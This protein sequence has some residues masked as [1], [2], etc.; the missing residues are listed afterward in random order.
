[1][2]MKTK[3]GRN[4]RC[5]CGSGKQ[6]KACCATQRAPTWYTVQDRVALFEALDGL[7]AAHF[8][9]EAAM[10]YVDFWGPFV[11]R[12][13]ELS[14][15]VLHLS[16]DVEFMAFVCDHE[17]EPH[18]TAIDLLLEQRS[19]LSP[20]ARA[21]GRAIRAA[22]LRAYEAIAIS[23]GVSITLR[24]VVNGR[25]V[26]VAERT[27][28]RSLNRFDWIA[29]RVVERGPSGKPEMERGVLAIPRSAH[30]WLREHLTDL[31]ADPDEG[32]DLGWVDAL[33]P[34]IAHQ[35]WVECFLEPAIPQL[36]NT[37]GELT[38][39]TRVHFDVK[40]RARVEAALDSCGALDRD[41]SRWNWFGENATGCALQL[42]SFEFKGRGLVLEANSKQRGERGAQ[43]LSQL[44]GDAVIHRATTHE[45]LEPQ[46]RAELK[47][48]ARGESPSAAA[49]QAKGPPIPP[50]IEEAL[51]LDYCGKHYRA[52][53]D[54]A[55]PALDHQTPR[56]A[57]TRP[58]MR[59]RVIELLERFEA[60]YQQCLRDGMPAYDASWIRAELGLQAAAAQLPPPLPHERLGS[61]ISG[62]S[63]RVADVAEAVR[64]RPGFDEASTVLDRESIQQILDVQ[65]FL[66][67]NPRSALSGAPAWQRRELV[68]Y[69]DLALNFMLHRRK[70]FWVDGALT[71]LLAQTNL[72]LP[73]RDL[74]TP[75]ASFALVFTDRHVLSQAERLLS[76][77][78]A[79]LAGLILHVATVLV[80]ERHGAAG[81]A[82][83]LTFAFDALGDDLP[84]LV[85]HSLPLVD[86]VP[87]Q[88][89]FPHEDE[90]S[91]L[92]PH[93]EPF[94]PL[95]ELL[96]ITV[97][98]I[99]YA[100]SSG[101]EVETRSAE[102]M[103]SSRGNAGRALTAESVFYLPGA[104]DVVLV[105]SLQ[106]LAR[107]DEGRR[108]MRR[109]LARGRW[110]K[111]AKNWKDQRLRWT[112]PHWKGPDLTAVIER[113][114][115]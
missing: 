53:I 62:A 102:S 49:P 95:P 36:Q 12:N 84:A 38:L 114:Y 70:A 27:A 5:P 35:L 113:A 68:P 90:H 52:W 25:T 81:R 71:Y 15:E 103:G 1:M 89:L 59:A 101:V 91:R 55:L 107:V 92:E 87:V 48:R 96:R 74:R 100:T 58:A 31:Y 11:G 63:R 7:I 23:P 26:T 64:M 73:A 61:F 39:I 66:T 4:D 24:D 65:R 2:H 105:R 72:E 99:V 13:E 47:A 37:D 83:D 111:A 82:L 88:S 28:S 98:A 93:I 9:V 17:L 8:Q 20:G 6:A 104:P 110:R 32:E 14:D 50:A 51:V 106:E 43:L 56:V 86:D 34:R 115:R 80:T 78:G 16:K 57:A 112:T 54:M 44:V 85:H 60:S 40:D 42:G 18:K 46:L 108:L 22:K 10:A 45:D 41:G 19:S 3:L 77:R 97:N 94:S 75:A 76:K 67:E 79:P 33:F 29:A 21:F 69:V 30:D 109:Y